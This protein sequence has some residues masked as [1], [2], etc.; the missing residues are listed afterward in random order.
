MKIAFLHYHLTPGGVTTVIRQQIEALPSGSESLM[1]SGE[2]GP[3][4]FPARTVVIPEIGYD[5]LDSQK[6]SPENSLDAS[7]T[8]EKI[9]QAISACWPDGCDIVHV[10]NPLLAKN[11]H[12]L[13]VLAELQKRG[14]RLL[15]QVHDFA[16][17]GRPRTYFR[18]DAYPAD[19][20]YCVINQRDYHALLHSGLK[21]GGLHLL[22][23]MVTP[24]NRARCPSIF[25]PFVLYPVRAIRRK[26]IGEAILHSLFFPDPCFLAITLPP[27]SDQDRLIHENWQRFALGHQLKVVFAASQKYL[28]PD[29]VASAVAMISTSISEGFGFSFLEPWTAG[30]MLYGRLL[31][32]VCADFTEKGLRLDHMYQRLD[33]P[34]C[35]IDQD[36]FYRQWTRCIKA[37]AT[38]YDLVLTDEVIQQAFKT[39]TQNQKIDFALLDEAFQ[40]Q[41]IATIAASENLKNQVLKMNPA[42]ALWESLVRQH[43]NPRPEN[44]NNNIIAHNNAVVQEY[45]SK[46]R[47]QEQVVKIYQKTLNT[48]VHQKIDKKALARQFL[49]LSQGPSP[50]PSQNPAQSPARFS[51]L[52][53]SRPLFSD[54]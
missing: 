19:A 45:F 44:G 28:F 6:K 53:W 5:S 2:P 34:L 13:K 4:D 49:S 46:S 29:L 11:R 40:Q 14:I 18:D 24:C 7:R 54:T 8:A 10:H 41:V 50:S 51:L 31:P 20:H 42:F 30:Q 21:P 16:E 15:L 35:W 3:E 17:D 22:P 38:I 48:R 32:E 37:C 27:N 12:F 52:K 33:I 9:I 23:N 25:D 47:Y 43:K 1:I 39:I 36:T 26:N